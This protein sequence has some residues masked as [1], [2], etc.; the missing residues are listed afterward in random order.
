[1]KALRKIINRQ[2]MR[3]L[4][5]RKSAVFLERWDKARNR[6]WIKFGNMPRT[7]ATFRWL[8]RNHSRLCR[9]CENQTRIL[10]MYLE[11]KNNP[12]I[13]PRLAAYC[14]KEWTWGEGD[15]AKFKRRHFRQ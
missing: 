5:K 7:T 4:R 8:E 9:V 11:E 10:S 12:E 15:V 3:R 6:L 14:G 2:K 1:M 13:F